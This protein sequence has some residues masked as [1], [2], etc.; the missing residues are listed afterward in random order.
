MCSD[1]PY[2]LH[3]IAIIILEEQ[4]NK[5]KRT[6][7]FKCSINFLR[8]RIWVWTESEKSVVYKWK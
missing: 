5:Y 2:L 1:I 3:D 4:I 7:D 8:K 6:E